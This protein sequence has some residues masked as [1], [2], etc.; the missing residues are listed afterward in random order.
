MRESAIEFLKAGPL[1][2]LTCLFCVWPFVGFAWVLDGRYSDAVIALLAE[3]VTGI[4][5]VAFV[6]F[7]SDSPMGGPLA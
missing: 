6:A 1:F 4:L 5:I 3:G 7:T 2:V